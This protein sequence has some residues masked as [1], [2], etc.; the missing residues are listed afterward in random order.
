MT[1]RRWKFAVDTDDGSGYLVATGEL[2]RA[3]ENAIDWLGTDAEA[4]AEAER[5]ADDYENLTGRTCTRIIYESQG[6]VQETYNT[7]KTAEL[8]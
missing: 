4:T 6:R 7:N 3:P 5:R 2:V 8:F 1:T